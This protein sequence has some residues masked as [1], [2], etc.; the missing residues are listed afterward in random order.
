MHQALYHSRR[1]EPLT[2]DELANPPRQLSPH[3]LRQARLLLAMEMIELVLGDHMPAQERDELR[4][5]AKRLGELA[6]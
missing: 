5:L 2:A 4:P 1:K 3:A 6:R